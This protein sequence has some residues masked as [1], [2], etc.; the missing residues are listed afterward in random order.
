[1]NIKSRMFELDEAQL[2]A[3]AMKTKLNGLYSQMDRM[4]P[5]YSTL[6]RVQAQAK[7]KG[8]QCLKGLLIDY[9]E[10]T[11]PQVSAVVDIAGK[12]K[13]FCA[14]VETIQDAQE[15]LQINKEV[16]GG[17]INIYPLESLD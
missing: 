13:F 2:Q 16:R 10:C 1:M 3:Q 11:N 17:V 5:I 8:S 15:L 7:S 4:E 14:I 6:R 12:Q 9:I